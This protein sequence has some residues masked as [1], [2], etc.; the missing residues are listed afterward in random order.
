[1][2]IIG[3]IWGK[4]TTHV[5]CIRGTETKRPESGDS[6]LADIVQE[7][8][9]CLSVGLQVSGNMYWAKDS[10]CER[11][12]LGWSIIKLFLECNGVGKIPSTYA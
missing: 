4:A 6:G 3:C 2:T 10:V 11:C 9:A 5:V 12:G 7:P 8:D 1:M